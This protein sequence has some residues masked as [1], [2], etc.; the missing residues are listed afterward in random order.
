[1][2]WQ[3]IAWA[4]KTR[5]GSSSKKAVLFALASH[6]DQFGYAWPGQ[7]LLASETDVKERQLRTLLGDLADAD[8]LTIFQARGKLGQLH[9]LYRLNFKPK[10]KSEM[11]TDH[12]SLSPAFKYFK[13]PKTLTEFAAGPPA[14]SCSAT[15]R[16][17][18]SHRHSSADESEGIYKKPYMPCGACDADGVMPLGTQAES[19]SEINGVPNAPVSDGDGQSRSSRRIDALWRESRDA[20]RKS[21]GSVCFR[22][23][24]EKAIPHADDGAVFV[25]A[26]SS[27]FV[28]D[29]IN[30][31]YSHRLASLLGRREVRAEF[32]PYA[33][34]A[35]QQNGRRER[36]P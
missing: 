20:I 32:H 21:V 34:R 35:A 9:N 28:A 14:E 6:C 30:R 7:D 17:L 13:G 36:S 8:L 1:M 2:S 25:L 26:A 12:P 22:N 5:A 15:G 33:K 24:F 3:A 10:P 19:Q 11:P 4:R 27:P 18:Q 23:I 31:E 16:V 29:F